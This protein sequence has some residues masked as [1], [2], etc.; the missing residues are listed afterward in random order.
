M[1]IGGLHSYEYSTCDDH[2]LVDTLF[3]YMLIA[4]MVAVIRRYV[5]VQ[6][7]VRFIRK[8]TRTIPKSYAFLW[9]MHLHKPTIFY[10]LDSNHPQSW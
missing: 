2:T 1:L 5:Q 10:G 4:H 6:K 3:I 7:I 9:F 8:A